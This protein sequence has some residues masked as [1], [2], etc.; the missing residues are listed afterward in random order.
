[1]K[2]SSNSSQLDET[3]QVSLAQTAVVGGTQG[4]RFIDPDIFLNDGERADVLS[5]S[6][7]NFKTCLIWGKHVKLNVIH[8]IPCLE[9]NFDMILK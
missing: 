4:L 3:D 2:R 8:F 6:F 9:G 5:A 1:M 7:Q